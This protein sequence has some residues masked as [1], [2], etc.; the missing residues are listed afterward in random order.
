MFFSH[1][2]LKNARILGVSVRDFCFFPARSNCS[3]HMDKNLNC[4]PIPN[5][6]NHTLHGA[7]ELKHSGSWLIHDVKALHVSK[8]KPLVSCVFLTATNPSKHSLAGF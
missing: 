3:L 6:Y 8:P 1:F 4:L 5:K 2:H 7:K